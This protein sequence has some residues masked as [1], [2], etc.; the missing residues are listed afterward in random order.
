MKEVLKIVLKNVHLSLNLKEIKQLINNKGHTVIN[1][2]NVRRRTTK[3]S[4]S[5]FFVELKPAVNNKDIYNINF[6]L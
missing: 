4:V 1:K 6:L 5:I 2:W 3:E